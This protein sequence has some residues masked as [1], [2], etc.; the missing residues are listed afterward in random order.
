VGPKDSLNAV[1]K[2][3]ILCPCQELNPDRPARSLA[4]ILTELTVIL[5]I[6]ILI[7]YCKVLVFSK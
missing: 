5:F 1:A 2:R 3:K 4:T 6:S 7:V